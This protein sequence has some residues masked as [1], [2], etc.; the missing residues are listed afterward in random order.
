[1]NAVTAHLGFIDRYL[2]RRYINQETLNAALAASD[3]ENR[4]GSYIKIVTAV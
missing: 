3:I 2:S 4:D 1:M